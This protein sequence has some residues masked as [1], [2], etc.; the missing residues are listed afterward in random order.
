MELQNILDMSTTYIYNNTEY[1]LT[2]RMAYK[3]S[4][5]SKQ[6]RRRSA[7][8]VEEILVEIKPSSSPLGIPNNDEKLWVKPTDLFVVSD[9]LDDDYFDDDIDDDTVETDS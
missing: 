5:A 7:S 1:V 2:G 4:V 8:I 6:R 3:K 9:A